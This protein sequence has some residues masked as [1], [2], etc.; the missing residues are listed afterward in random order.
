MTSLDDLK[1]CAED[2]LLQ[3]KDRRIFAFYGEMGAGKTTLIK[4]LCKALNV[5][6]QVSSPTF[7]IINEY[8]TIDNRR[9]YHADFYRIKDE[10]EAINIGFM[11]Y[12]YSGS[13]CF[14]EWSQKIDNLLPEDSVKVQINLM[15]EGRELKVEND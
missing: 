2:L 3:Y 6:D 5:I 15:K 12:L 9:V 8:E 4:E 10:Q 13:Y 11:D 7:S 14:I 1:Q